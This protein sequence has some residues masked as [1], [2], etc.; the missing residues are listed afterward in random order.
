MKQFIRFSAVVV[1]FLFVGLSMAS[2]QEVV[3]TPGPNVT[4]SFAAGNGGFAWLDV[5]G[6]GLPDLLTPPGTLQINHLTY[7]TEAASTRTAVIQ[8]GVNSCGLLMADFNGDGLPDI[9]SS[10]NSTPATGLW[11]DSA[12][13]KYVVPTGTGDLA[14]AGGTGEVFQGVAAA[15]IDHSNYLSLAW[16]GAFTNL[17][18]SAPY[19]VGGI[20]LLKGGPSGF[21]NIGNRA[22]AGNLAIDTL[23]SFETWDVHFFDANNDGYQDL[24]MV[25]FRNGFSRIDTGSS[26][27]AKGC[28]LFMNDG[29][30]K[31]VIPTGHYAIDSVVMNKAGNAD[32]LTWAS[33]RA[34]TGIVVDDTVRHLEA[35]GSTWGDLNNDGNPDLILT[36]LSS[37]NRTYGGK[38]QQI[39]VL[40]GKGDGTFTDKW[41]GTNYVASGLPTSG[42][43]RGWDIGDYNNDGIPDVYATYTYGGTN[44]FRGNGNGTYTDVSAQDYVQTAPSGGSHRSGGFVDYNNDGFLDLYNFANSY[45]QT[46][47]GNSNHWIGFVP[48]GAG[49]NLNAVGARFALYTQGGAFKQYRFIRAEGGDGG[50]Y[51][52]RAI[53]GI[54]INTSIDSVVVW[55]PDGNKATYTGLAVDKYWTI[56]EGSVVPG[57]FA[58]A[59]PADATTGAAQVDTLKWNPGSGAASYSVQVSMD[60]T[61]K[62]AGLMAVNKTVADTMYAYSLGPATKY[63]WRVAAVNGG[64]MSAY[65]AA[66]SFTTSGAAASTV[67]TIVTP[68]SANKVLKNTVANY[69]A[70]PVLEFTLPTGKTL[71]AYKSLTFKGYFASGDVGYKEIWVEANQAMPTGHAYATAAD[72]IGAY[73][74]AS[75]ASTAWENITVT[76]GNTAYSSTLSGTV[77]IN[78]GINCNGPATVWYADDVTLVDTSGAAGPKVDFESNNVGDAIAHIGWNATD[79]SSVVVTDPFSSSSGWPA[80][81]TFAVNKT[82]DASRYQWQVSTLSGFTT[83]A[84]NSMTADTT[85]AATLAGGQTYYLRVRG[86]ND[87]GASSYSGARTFTI[88]TPPTRT[89]LVTPANNALNVVSDS[90]MFVW[91][92]VSTATTYDLKVSTVNSSV[93]YTDLTDTT[94]MVRSLAKLT[95]YT[96]AVQ[97]NNAGGTSYYTNNF[98]FT[99]VITRPAAPVLGTPAA[100]ETDVNRT[101]TF[102]WSPVPTATKYNVQIA[103]DN[104]L[105]NLVVDTLVSF[106]T[107]Y[108]YPGQL[109]SSTAYFWAVRAWNDGGYSD[110]SSSRLFTTGTTGVGK[111]A[112]NVP[113]VYALMQNYPNPFNPTTTIQ[114][115]LPKASHVT[116]RVYDVLG[117]EVATLVDGIQAASSY[118]LQWNATAYAS[119]VYFYRIQAQSQDGSKSFTSVKKLLL[120]K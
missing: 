83:F 3:F 68:S 67:P 88:T 73:N 71:A 47:S 6:D 26:P 54:G 99:T 119:G 17:T 84:V 39:V 93:T 7:F 18:G 12:G 33:V 82:S 120:M 109:G 111:E 76:L 36:G 30:G 66:N 118:R 8:S 16:P 31:F 60:S 50:A 85:Y 97:A 70:A 14:S 15:P 35:I 104:A 1:I 43:I 96:W 117:R 32:S 61:F 87:L 24:L 51:E 89:T 44:I 101:A 49:N 13:V 20:W 112:N 45:L 81:L 55:W 58:L 34:D 92:K 41:N 78:F 103:T 75:G 102:T 57:T 38:I 48:V 114:Y 100:N 4:P 46:N 19:G 65:T 59:Y 5:N 74:R 113:K 107:T 42:S 79:I 25:S 2:A 37:D 115:D 91:R 40:Y 22:T 77:Y 64:F 52:M 53:F 110:L 116:L 105:A 9:F 69:N 10:N 95:N 94:Y 98:T 72:S 21:T 62:D 28:V 86:M 11:Y 80:K 106:D 108:T 90:V 27:A 56:K 23:S 63:F 29:T